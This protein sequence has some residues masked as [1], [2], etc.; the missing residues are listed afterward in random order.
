MQDARCRTSDKACYDNGTV[1]SF[2]PLRSCTVSN[3]ASSLG[4]G[5]AQS[6]A[7]R[8]PQAIAGSSES[9]PGLLVREAHGR[10]RREIEPKRAIFD[11][12][13]APARNFRRLQSLLKPRG[14]VCSAPASESCRLPKPPSNP[15]QTPAVLNSVARNQAKLCQKQPK[16]LLTSPLN[17][18]IPERQCSLWAA[19]LILQNGIC[20]YILPY[21]KIYR[22]Q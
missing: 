8:Q 7:L 20:L 3:I 12:P 14:N 19:Y 5:T 1:L 10:A 16:C 13:R 22:S 18:R 17:R 11:S 4:R 15:R 9:D 21:G 6:Q 2:C